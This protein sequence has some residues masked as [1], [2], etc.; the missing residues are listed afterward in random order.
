MCEIYVYRK[1]HEIVVMKAEF[2]DL[3]KFNKSALLKLHLNM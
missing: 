2:T 3:R 1:P